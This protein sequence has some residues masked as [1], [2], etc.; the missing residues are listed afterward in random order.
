MV[1]LILTAKVTCPCC[2]G[3]G[4]FS[5]RH[6]PGLIEILDCDCAFQDLTEAE[7]ARL[8]KNLEPFEIRP[9]PASFADDDDPDAYDWDDDDGFEDPYNDDSSWY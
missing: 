6:G 9:D 7:I 1:M 8:E 3:K 4:S 2:H 5:E